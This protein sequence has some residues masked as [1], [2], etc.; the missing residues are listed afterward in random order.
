MWN[1]ASGK[2][3]GTFSVK[4]SPMTTKLHIK[5]VGTIDSAFSM[6]VNTTQLQQHQLQQQTTTTTNSKVPV[7]CI[8]KNTKDAVHTISR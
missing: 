1:S 8:K 6:K 5:W 7:R 3:K 4:W 2:G